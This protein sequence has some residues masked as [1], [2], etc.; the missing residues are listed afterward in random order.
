MRRRGF[1][2]VVA[3]TALAGCEDV[4]LDWEEA[5]EFAPVGRLGDRRL[6]TA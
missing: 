6:G 2:S 5:E 3:A 4:E 1:L